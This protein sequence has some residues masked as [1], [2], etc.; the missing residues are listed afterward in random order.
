MYE[1]MEK[2][3]SYVQDNI[4]SAEILEV[5]HTDRIKYDYG[6][7]GGSKPKQIGII[8]LITPEF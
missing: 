6:D 3:K 1:Q 7:C 8:I 2:L 5:S 4:P